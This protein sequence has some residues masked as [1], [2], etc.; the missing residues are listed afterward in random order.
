MAAVRPP[1]PAPRIPILK[2]DIVIAPFIWRLFGVGLAV[3]Q[4]LAAGTLGIFLS[5]GIAVDAAVDGPFSKHGRTWFKIARL[6]VGVEL[7]FIGVVLDQATG[8][9]FEIPK[10]SR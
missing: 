1:M 9:V 7:V 5:A 10:V 6:P 8:R 4:K 2:E 3:G